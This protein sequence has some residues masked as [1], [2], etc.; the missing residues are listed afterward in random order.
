MD[1]YREG[2]GREGQGCGRCYV[3][4][5]RR[6]A[7]WEAC[8]LQV[9][10]PP[11]SQQCLPPCR[12]RGGTSYREEIKR[13]HL[14]ASRPPSRLQAVHAKEIYSTR[15]ARRGGECMGGRGD[16]V[17]DRTGESIR[18]RSVPRRLSPGLVLLSCPAI[19]PSQI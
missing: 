19:G 6:A 3:C 1:W 5:A 17:V 15:L 16:T 18:A 4:C 9:L 8:A 13:K 2:K 12:G 14:R 7:C 11:S 10:H